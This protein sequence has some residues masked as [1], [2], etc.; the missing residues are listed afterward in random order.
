V[1]PASIVAIYL[2]FWV[3]SAFLVLPFGLRT[4]DET[5]EELVQGQA[6]SA[7]VNFRPAKV[8]LRATIVS[9]VAFALFYANYVEDWVSIED[10]A[11]FQLPASLV[12]GK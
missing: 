11:P 2:L 8:A 7:P 1:K 4:P 5:G 12:E 3:I 9:A 6:N 10:I